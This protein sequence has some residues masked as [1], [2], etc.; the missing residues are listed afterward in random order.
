MRIIVIGDVHGCFDEA[1]DPDA[2]LSPDHLR[3]RRALED[4]HYD[5]FSKLPLFIP[6][7]EHGA[8][9]VHAGA[10]PDLP[11]AKQDPYHLLDKPLVTDHAVGIDTGCC[12][13]R[14]LTAV[15]L[16]GWTL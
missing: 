16:P 12:H 9:I 1:L 6:L 15:V 5:Y 11:I 3:T 13:G 14:T 8:V 2:K 7:P 4:R 10:M